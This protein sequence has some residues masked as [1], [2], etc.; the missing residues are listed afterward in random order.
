VRCVIYA[1]SKPIEVQILQDRDLVLREIFTEEQGAA[2]WAEEYRN[3]LK[4]HGW[5]DAPGDYSPSS[6]A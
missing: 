1:H 3:S 2:R 4:E 5:R 6:A